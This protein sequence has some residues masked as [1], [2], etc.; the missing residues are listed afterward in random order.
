MLPALVQPPFD[1][2]NRQAGKG[3]NLF[4]AH[5]VQPAQAHNEAQVVRQ[6]LN[7]VEQAI[8]QRMPPAVYFS[9]LLEM[10]FDGFIKQDARDAAFPP[11][12]SKGAVARDG[13]KPDR[14]T[15]GIVEIGDRP[16]GQQE[17]ILHDIFGSVRASYRGGNTQCSPAIA[18][19]QFTERLNVSQPSRNG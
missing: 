17:R 19:R 3:G 4:Q 15:L 6:M 12:H 16:K 13:G 8:R 14:K 10:M 7:F 9:D 2:G 5:F 11:D 18:E 1:G